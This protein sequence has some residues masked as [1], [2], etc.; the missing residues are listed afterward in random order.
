[1]KTL[2]LRIA[3]YCLAATA[4]PAAETPAQAALNLAEAL[5]DGSARDVV[6]AQS[7]LNPDT[8]DRKKGVIFETW[9]SE[10]KKMLP[11]PFTVAAEKI[12]GDCAAVVL[13]QYDPLRSELPHFIS[14]AIVRQAPHAAEEKKTA[15]AEPEWFAAPVPASFENSVVSYDD[16][17]LQ[18][19]RQLESWMLSREIELREKIQQD[20]K[21]QLQERI[22]RAVSP[23]ALAALDPKALMNAFIQALREKNHAAVLAY[24][25]GHSADSVINWD[26]IS[27]RI[28]KLFQGNDLRQW[29]WKLFADTQSMFAVSDPL[30][31]GD[32]LSLDVLVL[33]PESISEEPDYLSISILKD[34]QGRNYISLPSIFSQNEAAEDEL[35]EIMDYDDIGHMQLFAQIVADAKAH[36]GNADLSQSAEVAKIILQCLKNNDFR[37]YW[38]INACNLKNLRAYE[39]GTSVSFWQELQGK[40]GSSLFGQVGLK[41]HEDFA[42]LVLQTYSPRDNSGM[43]LKSIWLNRR[44]DTWH[45]TGTEAPEEGVPELTKW[46]ADEKKSWIANWSDSMLGDVAK[47][48]GLA[49]KGPD[50]AEVTRIF[51]AWQKDLQEKS[52][53]KVIT[54]CAAFDDPTSSLKMLRALAGELIYG[55]GTIEV[56]KVTVSGRWAGVSAVQSS[57]EAMKSSQYPLF[58]FVHTD[59]GPRLLPQVELK[60]NAVKN[61]SRE[62]LNDIAIKDL[63]KRL[64]DG[65]VDELRSL[66]TN[67]AK[68]VEEKTAIKP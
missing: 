59:K 60:L 27:F 20:I 26:N 64:P 62:Y 44:N 61:R 31:L 68:L 47:I 3:L 5:R 42:L 48:G 14:F 9:K 21:Q 58:L 19:R 13:H 66:Y 65:A 40:T 22:T 38:A 16:A 55:T 50:L 67:H 1:M 18:S 6:I 30:D 4:L 10:S 15:P 39:E 57:G 11:L 7:A 37:R 25:G 56:L 2:L 41:E 24:L 35:G 28:N 43:Q 33:H 17:V 34:P 32:E 8:G 12:N 49:A 53:T 36:L 29:P 52:F 45:I 51:F 54:H 46:F 63:G 23:E